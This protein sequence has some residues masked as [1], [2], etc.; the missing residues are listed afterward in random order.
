LRMHAAAGV[1][2]LL[3]DPGRAYLPKQGLTALA[4]MNV[5]TVADVEDDKIRSTTVWQ[6][7][8]PS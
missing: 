6:V 8:P 2:V 7:L 1:T 4:K 3:A 5:P